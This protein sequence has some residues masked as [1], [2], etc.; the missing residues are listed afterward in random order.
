MSRVLCTLVLPGN[1]KAV[2]SYHPAC[3]GD[4]LAPAKGSYTGPEALAIFAHIALPVQYGDEYHIPRTFDAAVRMVAE[5]VEPAWEDDDMLPDLLVEGR[6]ISWNAFNQPAAGRREA[7][8]DE[9]TKTVIWDTGTG[10]RSWWIGRALRL[11]GVARAARADVAKVKGHVS[12]E[13]HGSYS[14]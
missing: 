6:V 5:A 2:D 13:Q 11:A 7:V 9:T 8:Y 10:E 12:P 4:H 14:V 1:S 3:V